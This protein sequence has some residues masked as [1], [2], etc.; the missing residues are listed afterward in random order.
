MVTESAASIRQRL[1]VDPNRPQYHYLPPSNWMNDPN[2][3]IQ[4]R[5]TYHLFYQHN[6]NSPLW[7]DMH[8]GHATSDDLVHWADWPIALA[9]TPSGPDEA[10][11]FSGSAVNNNGVPTLIYTGTRGAHNEVQT[12]CIATSHDGLR[13]WQKYAGNPVLHDMP[14]VTGQTRDFRDPYVWREADAWYMVVGSRILGVG[15]VVFLYRS[16]D[17]L[18]WEYLH[19]L[20]INDDK[21][22]AD[23]IW[24][25]PNFFKLGDRWV[26]II[27]SHTG[28]T[29]DTVVYYVGSFE[30]HQFK[31]T[32][33]GILDNAQLYAPLTTRDDQN[34][35]ILI[36]WVRETRS[37][38]EMQA[39]GW[40]GVQ[41]VPR[42]LTLD[43][44]DRLCMQPIPTLDGLRSTHHHFDARDVA[45]PVKLDVHGSV[46][47]IQASFT[48]AT[49]GSCG[50]AVG[51]SADGSER[52]EIVYEAA[53][54]RLFVRIVSPAGIQDA[55]NHGREVRHELAPQEPLQLRILLDGSV[56]E[57]IANERTSLTSRLYVAR[58]A[59]DG[60]QLLGHKARLNTLDIWEMSSIWQ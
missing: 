4:W 19:P 16:P 38:D 50:L 39:A 58:A 59:S 52:L 25:C 29:T 13:T 8:W 17:L 22:Q 34:R 49:D 33:Q 40:S 18:K 51:C 15:G 53:A 36:G 35:M 56:V 28:T 48:P 47:D 3:F 37:R 21:K 20:L 1:A 12:Q 41:S 46:L 27:S 32:H 10:G 31:A 9:P 55:A 14:H 60:V 43:Q 11:C 57:I 5:G 42:V 30:N 2:G 26:L 7:G 44:H 45:A 6:P 24:E 54:Q 23:G